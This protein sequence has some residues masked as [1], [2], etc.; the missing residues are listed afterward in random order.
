MERRV[1]L[2]D[3]LFISIEP[4]AKYSEEMLYKTRLIY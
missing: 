1:V 4:E 2:L 3:V